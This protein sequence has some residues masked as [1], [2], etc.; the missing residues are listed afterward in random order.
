MTS[1]ELER[2]C[3]KANVNENEAN[4]ALRTVELLCARPPYG[5][6]MNRD[7]VRN[8]MWAAAALLDV[9]HPA[10]SRTGGEFYNLVEQLAAL[11]IEG[12]NGNGR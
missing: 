9:T 10:A 11:V 6:R 5:I 8:V 12:K 7:N 2:L 4:D 1:T 3:T